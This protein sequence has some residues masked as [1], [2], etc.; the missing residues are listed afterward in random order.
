[1]LQTFLNINEFLDV[2]FSVEQ[3]ALF[4]VVQEHWQDGD[5]TGA[6]SYGTVQGLSIVP[7]DKR[8]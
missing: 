4:K 5:E 1:M 7:K 3:V 8:G 6:F 2:L